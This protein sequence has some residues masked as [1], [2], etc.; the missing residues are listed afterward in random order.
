MS[1]K[2]L[3]IDR[4][5]QELTYAKGMYGVFYKGQLIAPSKKRIY[6]TKGSA[7]AQLNNIVYYTTDP[8][9]K[10]WIKIDK[11]DRVDTI[12]ELIKDGTIEIKTV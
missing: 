12:D 6:K 3:V 10:A 7:R 4:L 9:T 8:T 2:Q 11:K 1:I 5:E